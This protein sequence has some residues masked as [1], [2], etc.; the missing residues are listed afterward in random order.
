MPG[1]AGQLK[2]GSAEQRRNHRQLP[3]RKK[4]NT[5]EIYACGVPPSNMS[6]Y[7]SFRLLGIG[8]AT[9][10]WV[11]GD[12][13]ASGG[14]TQLPRQTGAQSKLGSTVQTEVALSAG[15]ARRW[16]FWYQSGCRLLLRCRRPQ[17]QW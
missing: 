17:K 1:V 6:I 5:F 14:S 11:C 2:R 10:A 16:F 13:Q 3:S 9:G 4:L 15:R 7:L 12:R 8:R